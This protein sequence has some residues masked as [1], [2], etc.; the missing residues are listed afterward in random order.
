MI[1]T[2]LTLQEITL[3]AAGHLGGKLDCP[4]G[5]IPAPGQYLSAHAP[6]LNEALPTPLFAMRIFPDGLHLAPPL[7]ATWAAGTQLRVRGPLGKGFHLPALARRVALVALGEL[8][9]RLLPLV[10]LAL[11][12]DAAVTLYT[13]AIP[14]DLPDEVEILPLDLTPEAHHWADYLALDL[15]LA[16][17]PD[18]PTV[19]GLRPFERLACQAQALVVTAMP[20]SGLAECGVCAVPSGRSWKLAC[21]DGPVVDVARLLDQG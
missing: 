16:S 8:P 17:L 12:Q 3:E 18:L 4:A 19:L 10:H 15:P 7:P 20:C 5:L 1:E 9:H 6:A 21:K 2:T 13:R 14:R 11:R